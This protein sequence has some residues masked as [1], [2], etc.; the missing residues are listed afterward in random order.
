MTDSRA[1]TTGRL[2]LALLALMLVGVA[3]PTWADPPAPSDGS[4][5]YT[6]AASAAVTTFR[7]TVQ[8]YLSCNIVDPSLELSWNSGM[9]WWEGTTTV[10]VEANRAYEFRTGWRN[11]YLTGYSGSASSDLD[12]NH[13]DEDTDA[14][15]VAERQVTGRVDVLVRSSYAGNPGPTLNSYPGQPQDQLNV[16]FNGGDPVGV[17]QVTLFAW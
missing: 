17:V 15:P 11:W 12:G 16:T 8:D 9:R 6:G 1:Q 5:T 3:L 14:L 4:A 13:G 2:L 10:Q 7:T